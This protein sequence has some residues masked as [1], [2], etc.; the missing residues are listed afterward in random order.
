MKVQITVD[1]QVWRRARIASFGMGKTLGDFVGLALSD[2]LHVVENERW[3]NPTK[4]SGKQVKLDNREVVEVDTRGRAPGERALR[5][6]EADAPKPVQVSN[7]ALPTIS[8]EL[9][10]DLKSGYGWCLACKVKQVKLPGI[11]CPD[12]KKG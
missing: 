12:C 7:P 1:E 10:S 2:L 3:R 9:K 4:E 5:A 8:E 11:L 6:V